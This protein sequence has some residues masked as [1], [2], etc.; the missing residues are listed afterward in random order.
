MSEAKT[1]K[2]FRAAAVRVMRQEFAGVDPTARFLGRRIRTDAVIVNEADEWSLRLRSLA[3]MALWDGVAVVAKRPQVIARAY[4]VSPRIMHDDSVAKALEEAARGSAPI[5]V[6]AQ[7][8]LLDGRVADAV[9]ATPLRD[10]PEVEGSLLALRAGTGFGASDAQVASAAGAVA[11]LEILRTAQARRDARTVRQSIALFEIARRALAGGDLLE[12]FGDLV[13]LM[14]ASLSHDLV[15]IWRLRSGGSLQLCAAHPREGLAV[16]IAR[17][18]DHAALRGALAG[19]TVRAHDPS[20]RSW[21]PRTTRDLIVAPLTADG[22]AGVLVVGRWREHYQPDDED[23]A[24][25]CARFVSDAL[26]GRAA[27]RDARAAHAIEDSD[28]TEELTGT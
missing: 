27:S 22:P 6:F 16:E 12:T 7:V 8:P 17:P 19:T 2:T 13:E 23:M 28:A 18:R 10:V 4:N 5:Q 15:Q 1:A 14:A 26:F 21:L 11:A 3:T 9:L 20:L 25:T 24:A